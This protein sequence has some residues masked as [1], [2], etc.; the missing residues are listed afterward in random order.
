M[1]KRVS[2]ELIP[3]SVLKEWE[4]VRL[5][6]KGSRG[7]SELLLSTSL[8]SKALIA[9]LFRVEEACDRRRGHR[10]G[11]PRSIK[12]VR[13]IWRR[14]DLGSERGCLPIQQFILCRVLEQL[15]GQD[16]LK[17]SGNETVP[18]EQSRANLHKWFLRDLLYLVSRT[19]YL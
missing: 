3:E 15:G 6:V 2:R 13:A 14:V 5:C 9:V 17:S 7:T 4:E 1:P 19:M 16:Q 12:R 10:S 11:G 8:R 18:N